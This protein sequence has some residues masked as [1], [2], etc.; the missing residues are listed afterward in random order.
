SRLLPLCGICLATHVRTTVHC[1]VPDARI[2]KRRTR[3]RPT[4]AGTARGAAS[5]GARRCRIGKNRGETCAD[6][7]SPRTRHPA[8]RGFRSAVAGRLDGPGR[9]D[10]EGRTL[11]EEAALEDPGGV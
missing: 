10:A 3:L 8:G 9:E 11:R 7:Q 4:R 5:E 1:P 6:E 2:R